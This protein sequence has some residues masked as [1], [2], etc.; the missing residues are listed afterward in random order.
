VA[1]CPDTRDPE[2]ADLSR[3]S[4]PQPHEL[5]WFVVQ[6]LAL[7]V[8]GIVAYFAVRGLTEGSAEAAGDNASWI[9]QVER[10]AGLALE[11]RVQDAAAWSEVLVTFGNWVYIWC[12]W[13]LVVGTLIWL[14]RRHRDDYVE[15][16]NALFISGA[17]GLVIYA[18]FPVAPPRLFSP[19]FVDTVTLRSHSYR[20]LQPPGFTNIYAAV[21]SLHFGW[22]L[23][24]GRSWVRVGRNRAWTVAG[25]AM[26]VAMAWAVV[27]TANHWAFDVVAGGLV[28]LTGLEI[29]RIRRRHAHPTSAAPVSADNTMDAR[30]TSPRSPIG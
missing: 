4:D 20:V 1:R 16:R 24:V 22:N 18:T 23:L 28:A 7:V 9:Y 19:E 29:E 8:G 27:V 5:R 26:P 30:P 17:I 21:P 13:P 2:H 10:T 3:A 11:N 6:Q 25:V 15:L 14:L 12:H